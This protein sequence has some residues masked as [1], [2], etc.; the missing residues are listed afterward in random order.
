MEFNTQFCTTVE[1]SEQLLAMGLKPE[2]ADCLLMKADG[3]ILVYGYPYKDFMVED[4]AES[5]S[6][7]VIPAW[8]LHRLM[9]MINR[10]TISLMLCNI[11]YDKIIALIKEDIDNMAKIY[12]IL[13]K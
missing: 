4:I 7:V 12:K 13:N 5:Y 6:Q 10:P 2:T 8:S 9:A 11:T 3:N 1:Q